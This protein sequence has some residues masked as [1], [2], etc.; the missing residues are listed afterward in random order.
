MARMYVDCREMPNEV[1]CSLRISGEKDEV[2]REAIAHAISVHSEPDT[3]ELREG[4]RDGL[5]LELTEGT[6]VPTEP[7][8]M[9]ATTY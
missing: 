9:A 4:L 5:K 8:P 3:P 6:F 1:G 7:V 2:L